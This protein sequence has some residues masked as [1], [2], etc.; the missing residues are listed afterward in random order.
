MVQSIVGSN[1]SGRTRC[2][3]IHQRV[4]LLIFHLVEQGESWS[5]WL[6]HDR[7]QI[8]FDHVRHGHHLSALF[9]ISEGTHSPRLPMQGLRNLRAQRMHFVNGSM[10]TRSDQFGAAGLW[11]STVG[12]LLVCRANVAWHCVGEIGKS[13][14]WNVFVARTTARC[15]QFKWNNVRAQFEVSER[16]NASG[17]ILF[18]LLEWRFLIHFHS[19]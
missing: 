19:H 11:S 2:S 15:I 4:K 3:C 16:S 10:Q 14:S 17:P 5:A 8:S 6:P 18:H 7:S 12:I 13:K 1:V 9:E